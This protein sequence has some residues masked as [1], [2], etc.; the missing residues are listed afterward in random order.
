MSAEYRNRAQRA[1]DRFVKRDAIASQPKMPT[2]IKK[3][4]NK[5]PE[6][7]L[8]LQPCLIW[9]KQMGWS[10]DIYES[11]A[12]WDSKAQCYVTKGL[13]VG[14]PDIAGC[15]NQGY[16]VYCE[17]KAPGKRST[18][19]AHQRHFLTTKAQCGAF[20]CV[21]DDLELLKAM[22]AKWISMRVD[23]HFNEAV[24]FLLNLLRDPKGGDDFNIE[25]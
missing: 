16:A 9:M 11:K 18:V 13:R 23:G 7:D 19:K 1:L 8:V 12:V 24:S 3:A 2:R 25:S 17:T 4:K 10:V 20:S 6:F 5:K 14:H 22:W 21:I 15:T